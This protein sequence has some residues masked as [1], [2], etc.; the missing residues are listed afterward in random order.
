MTKKVA[1]DQSKDLLN[2][3]L[4][5][6]RIDN[7]EYTLFWGILDALEEEISRSYQAKCNY[8]HW[9]DDCLQTRADRD[10]WKA[11]VDELTATGMFWEKRAEALERAIKET[12][13]TDMILCD[14]CVYKSIDM[15][16]EPCESCNMENY[17]QFDEARFTG[18]ELE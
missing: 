17:Y 12:A 3:L 4:E 9:K 5:A 8:D 15:E 6:E 1:V 18:G 14:T 7:D 10:R 13:G 16:V 11:L 2:R